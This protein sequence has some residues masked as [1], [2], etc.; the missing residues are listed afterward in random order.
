[1]CRNHRT[2]HTCGHT[3]DT[4]KLCPDALSPLLQ[5]AS[6]FP[7]TNR[8]PSP[9][10]LRAHDVLLTGEDSTDLCDDCKQEQERGVWAEVLE[11]NVTS[12]L[13]V[14]EVLSAEAALQQIEGQEQPE[15]E[16]NPDAE[17]Q[18]HHN[19]TVLIDPAVSTSFPAIA[20]ASSARGGGRTDGTFANAGEKPAT[21]ASQPAKHSFTGGLGLTVNSTGRGPLGCA[22]KGRGKIGNETEGLVGDEKPRKAG[23]FVERNGKGRAKL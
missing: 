18:Q 17:K 20:G 7:Y 1:M 19:L 16:K 3:A 11:A 13:D 22:S 10:E 21:G 14:L 6:R 8:L 4:I 2:T 9:A 12:Y 15:M 23:N 5:R